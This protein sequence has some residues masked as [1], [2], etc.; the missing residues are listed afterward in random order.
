MSSTIAECIQVVANSSGL[1]TFECHASTKVVSKALSGQE[2]GQC[3]S[4]S[5]DTFRQSLEDAATKELDRVY[6]V[7]LPGIGHS[8]AVAQCSEKVVV[9][10][11]WEACYSLQEWLI[12]TKSELAKN[13]FL[14][15]KGACDYPV[16]DVYL[17][18]LSADLQRRQGDKVLEYVKALFNPTG[19]RVTLATVAIRYA[20][21]KALEV[22]W[23]SEPI[24]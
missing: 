17:S 22:R 2:I 23:D 15:K 6:R 4:G 21:G 9:L 16:L 7:D 8:F 13:P 11:S 3:E 20:E 5:L 18:T 10:Q 1:A 14:P 12:G 19:A 24:Q